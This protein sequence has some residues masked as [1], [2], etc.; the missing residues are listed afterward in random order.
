MAPSWH[1]HLV[2]SVSQIAKRTGIFYVLR[3]RNDTWP[4]KFIH[5]IV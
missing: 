1:P 3:S 2:G 4:N 5:R